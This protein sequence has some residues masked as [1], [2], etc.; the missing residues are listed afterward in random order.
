M[1][2]C[3]FSS[4]HCWILTHVSAPGFE[5]CLLDLGGQLHAVR[6][7]ARML[8]HLL[9]RHFP[10]FHSDPPP[11]QIAPAERGEPGCEAGADSD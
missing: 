1:S 6:H 4:I 8:L 10:G 3:V 2:K 11:H 9:L 5:G 7:L